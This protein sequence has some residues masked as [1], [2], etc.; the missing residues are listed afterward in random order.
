ML[1]SLKSRGT[2]PLELYGLGVTRF[3]GVVDRAVWLH[4]SRQCRSCGV[5]LR[6]LDSVFLAK[7]GGKVRLYGLPLRVLF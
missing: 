5:V 4:T 2:C 6:S 1:K 3:R 7:G